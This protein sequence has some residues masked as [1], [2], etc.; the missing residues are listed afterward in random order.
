MFGNCYTL[1]FYRQEMIVKQPIRDTE[2]P[3]VK[4][5]ENCGRVMDWYTEFRH[6][7]IGNFRKRR[8]CDRKCADAKK[9]LKDKET[10]RIKYCLNCNREMNWFKEY[11]DQPMASWKTRKYCS[12]KC[13]NKHRHHPLTVKNVLRIKPCQN[14]GRVMDWDKEFRKQPI[15]SFAER[16]FCSE[17]CVVEGQIRYSGEG[18]P[19]YNPDSRRRS[20]KG[21]TGK[22]ISAVHA[23]CDY[24]CQH[25][26]VDGTKQEVYLVAHHIKEW[27]KYPELRFDV[28]NGLTLCVKCHDKVHY[29]ELDYGIDEDEIIEK[30]T[31]TSISRRVKVKCTICDANLYKAPSDLIYYPSRKPK[32][33]IFCSRK[34]VGEYFSK[35]RTGANNPRHRNYS[36]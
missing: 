8:F 28:D 19:N 32:K 33:H 27:A 13:A 34:C 25:C 6:I 29:G 4:D 35:T 10:P 36:S 31:P 14:C 2:T 5:C 16:K 15:T 7:P 21:S 22:W 3:R 9:E 11:R 1:Q 12:S 24:T 18:H 17:K 20:R 26:G 23:K 30:I